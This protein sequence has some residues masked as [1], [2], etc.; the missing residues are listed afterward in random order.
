MNEQ[1]QELINGM[2]VLAEANKLCYDAH[3]KI[4]FTDEQAMRMT[5]RFFTITYEYTLYGASATE[6]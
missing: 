5:E 4:G 6:E 3:I 1:I 2:G